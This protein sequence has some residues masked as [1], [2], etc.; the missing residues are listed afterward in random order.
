[1]S[2]EHVCP[3]GWVYPYRFDPHLA[4]PQWCLA[5]MIDAVD[6]DGYAQD[7]QGLL[8][9]FPEFV[10]SDLAR[11]DVVRLRGHFDDPA[12]TSCSAETD[13]GFEG[14]A[15]DV[16]FLVLFCREQFVPDDWEL[17]DHRELA[18]SPWE[19]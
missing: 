7:G 2:T 10:P 12:A 11:G 4:A 8:V 1:M 5:L 19:S 18:P 3:E 6:L 16:P 9:R 14:P 13:P 17:I 15:V